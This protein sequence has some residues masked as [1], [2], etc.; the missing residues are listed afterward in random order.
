[1]FERTSVTFSRNFSDQKE[2]NNNE[3][4]TDKI[5]L[6]NKLDENMD[7]F[8]IS[9]RKVCLYIV[10]NND[11]VFCIFYIEVCIFFFL[12]FLKVKLCKLQPLKH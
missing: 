10:H 7:F 8:E 5:Q 4:S 12:R 1:M 3:C 11:I 2:G 6:L 9:C